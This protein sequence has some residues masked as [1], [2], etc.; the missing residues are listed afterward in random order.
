[1]GKRDQDSKLNQLRRRTSTSF[2]EAQHASRRLREFMSEA[3][4]PV[5]RI[6][7]VTR[8]KNLAR[9]A[10]RKTI[11][12]GQAIR[13][14]QLMKDLVEQKSVYSRNNKQQ[15]KNE[16]RTPRKALVLE[17]FRATE[18]WQISVKA[19]E[20]IVVFRKENDWWLVGREENEL[21]KGMIPGK[22]CCWKILDNTVQHDNEP[23]STQSQSPVPTFQ[24]LTIFDDDSGEQPLKESDVIGDGNVRLEEWN[25]DDLKRAYSYLDSLIFPTSTPC[26][27]PHNF[28]T[29]CQTSPQFER[30]VKRHTE[31]LLQDRAKHLRP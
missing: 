22:M 1:M 13:A 5:D 7:G 31:K 11:N 24:N 23:T 2:A 20:H 18:D 17:S 8:R 26:P 9:L 14:Q 6:K 12:E 10:S 19:G 4:S 16:I 30:C 15:S 25:E 28:H 27:P 3:H 21:Q 29:L